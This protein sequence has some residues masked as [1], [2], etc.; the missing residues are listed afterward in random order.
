[1][2]GNFNTIINAHNYTAPGSGPYKYWFFCNDDWLDYKSPPT[3]K[4]IQSWDWSEL[5]KSDISNIQSRHLQGAMLVLP[6]DLAQNTDTGTA[7]LGRRH[8]RFISGVLLGQGTAQIQA[9]S[10][11]EYPEETHGPMS[12]KGDRSSYYALDFSRTLRTPPLRKR[13]RTQSS[14]PQAQVSS[15]STLGALSCLTSGAI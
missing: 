8:T 15:N 7:P 11:L 6:S 3:A 9:G 5:T 2:T 1:M 12:C 10:A 4:E 13:S 14:K